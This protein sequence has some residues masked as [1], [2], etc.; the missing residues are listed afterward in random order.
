MMTEIKFLTLNKI[1]TINRYIEIQAKKDVNLKY[2]KRFVRISIRNNLIDLVESAEKYYFK[3]NDMILTATYY[4]KNIIILQSLEDG[5]HRTAITATR[6]FLDSNGYKTKVVDTECYKD[7]KNTL[8][9]YRYKEYF[10][11]DS[12]DKKVLQLD[13]NNIEN[14]VFDYCLKFIKNKM[15]R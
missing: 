10:T 4:L 12:L 2:E 14:Y 3:T 6:I 7:F 11:Y 8:F 1:Y 13:D 9:M 15:L 5:N